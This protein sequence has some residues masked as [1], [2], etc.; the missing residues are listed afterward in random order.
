MTTDPRGVWLQSI[1]WRETSDGAWS[2]QVVATRGR[3]RPMSLE[4]AFEVALKRCVTD[5]QFVV[6]RLDD[7]VRLA[8]PWRDVTIAQTRASRLHDERPD[9]ERNR[10]PD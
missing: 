5:K 6:E 1:G 2:G 9:A 4:R 8:L 10:E 3:Y 7:R